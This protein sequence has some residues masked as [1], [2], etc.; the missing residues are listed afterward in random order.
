MLELA[1]KHK[2]GGRGQMLDLF[3]LHVLSV[4]AQNSSVTS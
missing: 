2:V 3:I 4:F 1:D